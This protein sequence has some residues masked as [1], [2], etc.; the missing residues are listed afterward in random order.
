MTSQCNYN[1]VILI[2]LL[3]YTAKNFGGSV[4]KNYWQKNLNGLVDLHNIGDLSSI[5]SIGVF[6]PFTLLLIAPVQNHIENNNIMLADI[7]SQ[8]FSCRMVQ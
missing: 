8:I 7:S 3:L 6:A 4:P 1:T 2:H 5:N